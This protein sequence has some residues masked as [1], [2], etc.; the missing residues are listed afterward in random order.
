MAE[1]RKPLFETEHRTG[2]AVTGTFDVR[3]LEK[4]T[5]DQLLDL[6]R[7]EQGK[8]AELQTLERQLISAK[9]A[10]A[11]C[12]VNARRL[13]EYRQARFPQMEA[14]PLPPI[15]SA[16]EWFAMA[17]EQNPDLSMQD[18]RRLIGMML[19]TP[20][21]AGSNVQHVNHGGLRSFERGKNSASRDDQRFV[22]TTNERG[23]NSYDIEAWH[24]AVGYPGSYSNPS[25][26]S[27]P[28]REDKLDEGVM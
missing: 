18:A 14:A 13:R 1:K 23:K 5:E 15:P 25:A 2:K 26:S 22:E 19:A 8:V 17:R 4:L 20:P 11:Y 21:L 27:E 3:E 12:E 24:S 7:V 6:E 10:S 28:P 9:E 16:E